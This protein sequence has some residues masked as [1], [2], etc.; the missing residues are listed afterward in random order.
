MCDEGRLNYRFV[1]TD[2]VTACVTDR[3][4][5][6]IEISMENALMELRSMVGVGTSST[7]S[8]DTPPPQLAILVS[9]TCTLE[10][11]FMAK[12]LAAGFPG[13]T[14]HAVRHVPD[15][16]EDN[17]LRKSDRHPNTE[18]ARLL[19]I[20][21]IDIVADS[22]AGGAES[23]GGS[24]GENA[25]LLAVG[26]DYGIGEALESVFGKF[27]KIAVISACESSLTKRAGLLLPGLTFAEKEG[28]IVN[29]E[30]R[31]QRLL[32]ALDGLWE[33]K[34]PW[35]ILADLVSRRTGESVVD[36]ITD[37]RKRLAEE[38]TAFSGLDLNA[39]GSGRCAHSK[40]ARVETTD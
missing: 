40:A 24:G 35:E 38:E 20:P 8:A 34:S 37:L 31:I 5:D 11:M 4:G 16:V 28:L 12:R 27:T 13:A 3:K 32:P 29:F 19:D 18:G 26:F 25:V 10:E 22:T 9:A 15:G 1:N 17:L 2:R 30:G 23:L 36:T 21:T 6:K 7:D 39:V 33:K 14:L